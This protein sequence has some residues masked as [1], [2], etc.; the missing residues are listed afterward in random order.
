[1]ISNLGTFV[2][3]ELEKKVGKNDG[4]VNGIRYFDC[5]PQY[6]I[7]T[8][9]SR[10]TKVLR[11]KKQ[12]EIDSDDNSSEISLTISHSST[13][14]DVV[15]KSPLNSRKS[16]LKSNNSKN[17]TSNT[18]LQSTQQSNGNTWLTVGVNV[19]INNSIG[20][21]RYI[22]PVDFAG[23]GIWLGMSL[24]NT[25]IICLYKMINCE[26]LGVELRSPTGKNDGSVNGIRYF[27]CK[28]N[29]GL[30]VRPKKVSVRGINGAKLLPQ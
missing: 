20:V 26:L 29:H 3:I 30:L 22:G 1:M 18:S 13:D 25:F 10:I 24:M 11:D 7:F 17:Q 16:R 9:I 8:T 28:P 5:Q 2:G 19:F 6:G 12:N 21:V 23:P 14:N 4:S 27:Q 15:F